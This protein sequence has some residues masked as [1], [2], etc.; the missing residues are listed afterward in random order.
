MYLAKNGLLYNIILR[1][2][3]GVYEQTIELL[4]CGLTK[5]NRMNEKKL[6]INKHFET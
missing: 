2:S 3:I 4:K 5:I 6:I 1:T